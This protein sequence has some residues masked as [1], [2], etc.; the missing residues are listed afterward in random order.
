[1]SDFDL[2]T[3]SSFDRKAFL[4]AARPVFEAIV[5]RRPFAKPDWLVDV[6]EVHAFADI[7]GSKGSRIPFTRCVRFGDKDAAFCPEKTCSGEPINVAVVNVTCEG[8]PKQFVLCTEPERTWGKRCA[9]YVPV[10][11]L[12]LPS[13]RRTRSS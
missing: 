10:E 4:E 9:L 11:H 6:R 3:M 13:L 7:Q 5:A 2:G 1:M 12:V 8:A